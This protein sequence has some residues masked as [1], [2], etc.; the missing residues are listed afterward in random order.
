MTR[1][2]IATSHPVRIAAAIIICSGHGL[3]QVEAAERALGI[4]VLQDED[5]DGVIEVGLRRIDPALEHK[6]VAQPKARLQRA[7]VNALVARLLAQD[8]AVAGKAR[9]R[10]RTTQ[11]MCSTE[12]IEPSIQEVAHELTLLESIDYIIGR[13]I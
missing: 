10:E 5:P 4:G 9:R 13:E 12:L 11:I 7:A 2:K 1:A 8:D 6:A 3:G